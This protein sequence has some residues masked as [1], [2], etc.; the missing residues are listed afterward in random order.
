MQRKRLSNGIASVLAML[1]AT[2]LM[3][4]TSAVAQTENVLLNFG[5]RNGQTPEA[6]L[7]FDA[8]GNLYGTTAGGGAFGHGTAFELTPNGSGGWTEK[9]LHSFNSN[10]KDGY[11]PYASLVL[12]AAGNLYGTTFSGGAHG[13]GTVFELT[14]NGSGGWSEKQLHSFG[15]IGTDGYGP[16]GNLILDAAGNLYGTTFY[17]GGTRD[18]GTVFELM[19]VTGGGWKEKILLRF[20]GGNGERPLGGLIFD[21]SGNLYGT[22]NE[23][24]AS[25]H[26]TVFELTPGTGGT[27]TTTVLYNFD[28]Y[29][30][31]YP[32][33]GLIFDGAGN[34]YGTTS[35]GGSGFGNVF[36]LTPASGGG[37]TESVLLQFDGGSQGGY[38]CQNLISDSAGNVYG[39]T[40]IGGANSHGTV[41]ELTPAT[42]GVWAET[43]LY[44]FYSQTGG[45]DGYSP[46]GGVVRDAAGNLY[47]TTTLGGAHK[48]GTVFEVTP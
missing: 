2:V 30:G 26:G 35:G 22:A 48:S 33:G 24:G 20:S 41:F 40:N 15:G 42:G 29:D 14:P 11:L 3:T 12:D 47:G 27:W 23:G 31:A 13:E 28:S 38:P 19:P 36:E 39:T 7:I 8:A 4:A 46:V 44:S 9:L 43:I 18:Y 32:A 25:G 34:L 17:G 16:Y 6:G 21:S 5:S 10:G 37:W 1:A 45:V